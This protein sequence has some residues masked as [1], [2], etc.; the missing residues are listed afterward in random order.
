MPLVGRYPSFHAMAVANAEHLKGGFGEGLVVTMLGRSRT[1][2]ELDR[3]VCLPDVTS[4][5][6]TKWKNGTEGSA[7]NIDLL[8]AVAQELADA[9]ADADDS[10]FGANTDK[11]RGLFR[12]L[13]EVE[14]SR[15]INGKGP[16]FPKKKGAGKPKA[17]KAAAPQFSEAEQ[18]EYTQA[19]ASAATKFDNAEVFFAKNKM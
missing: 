10:L 13:I 8:R 4:C 6:V 7:N 15:V 5:A 14:T 16:A 9:D 19:I 12:L 18:A 3:G 17:A 1:R 2:G 11:A